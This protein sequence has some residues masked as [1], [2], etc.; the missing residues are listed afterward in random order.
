M[1]GERAFEK[2]EWFSGR[3]M[4]KFFKIFKNILPLLAAGVL[5]G[6]MSVDYVGQTFPALPATDA[7]EVFSPE[8]PMPVSGYRI[9]GRVELVAPPRT[10]GTAIR[11]RLIE[12]AREKGAEA[13]NIV[14]FRKV[15]V[16]FWASDSGPGEMPNYEHDPRNG[17]GRFLYSNSFG[18]PVTLPTGRQAMYDSCVQAQLL[19]SDARFAQMEQLY[20]RQME[21]LGKLEQTI[22]GNEN[23]EKISPDRILNQTVKPV[24]VA[25]GTVKTPAPEPRPLQINLS[26]DKNP[27][28][29]L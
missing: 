29:K 3:N 24:E 18:N 17:G 8:N 6:C 15:Q 5:S 22:A 20:R 13:V 12:L 14:S 16:G 25:P 28:V 9:M 2:T 10:K 4:K 27:A 11:Q 26:N 1:S 21:R 19:V 7:I 23:T